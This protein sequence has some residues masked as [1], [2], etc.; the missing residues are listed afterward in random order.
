MREDDLA[1]RDYLDSRNPELLPLKIAYVKVPGIVAARNV[2]MAAI[3]SDVVALIDDDAVPRPDW[4]MKIL[5]HFRANPRLGG[6]GGRDQCYLDGKPRPASNPVVGKLL[7]YGKHLGNH[8][9][10]S[11]SPREVDI[12]KGVNMSYRRSAIEG[13]A[14][15]TRLRGSQCADDFAFSRAVALAG[16]KLVYDPAVLVD[17]YEGARDDRRHYASIQTTDLPGF[18][19]SVHNT[20]LAWWNSLTP[21][22]QFA[23][24]FFFFFIGTRTMPGLVQAIRF[25]PALGRS[26]WLRFVHAQEGRRAAIRTAKAGPPRPEGAIPRS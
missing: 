10:G 17:H 8:N 9:A 7:W 26:S 15:D 2:G 3:R 12:L 18:E 11:G 6:L 19:D 23:S 14:F 16:W 20:V 24:S 4:V 25:T 5:E 21:V 1:T 22:G 13:L